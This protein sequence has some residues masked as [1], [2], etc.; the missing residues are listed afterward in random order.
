MT[1]QDLTDFIDRHTENGTI[2]PREPWGEGIGIEEKGMA[3]VRSLVA[4]DWLALYEQLTRKSNFWL[5]CL[6]ELLDRVG[7]Q[8]ARQM[9]IHIALNGT[10]E[11]F[12]D[13]MECIHTFRR[14]VSVYTWLKL[15]NR[16]SQI[17][18]SKSNFN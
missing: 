16:S 17:S 14:D 6:I 10:E 12:F 13:A 7:T 4:N 5:E 1:I 8:Q 18:K 2:F 9:I 11:S 15:K 3:L